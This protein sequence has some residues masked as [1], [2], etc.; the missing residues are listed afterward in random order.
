MLL[1]MTVV[2]LLSMTP[3]NNEHALERTFLCRGV[4]LVGVMGWLCSCQ[5][6]KGGPAMS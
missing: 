6:T 4:L 1:V 3:P 5:V 2:S